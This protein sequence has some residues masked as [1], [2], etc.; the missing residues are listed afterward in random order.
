MQDVHQMK[1]NWNVSTCGDRGKGCRHKEQEGGTSVSPLSASLSQTRGVRGGIAKMG[2][3]EK[4][5]GPIG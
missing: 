1:E 3:I 5:M 2:P 4:R